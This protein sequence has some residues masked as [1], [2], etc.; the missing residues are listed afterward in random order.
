M[1]T[2]G[3]ISDTHG[4]LRPQALAALQGCDPIIHAGDVGSPDILPAL[5]AIAPVFPVRGNVDYGPWAD[6]LPPTQVIEIEGHRIYVLH[7]LDELKGD[8]AHGCEAVIYG[9]SHQPKIETRNGTL[10]FNPGSAGPRRFRL[11]ITLGRVTI[12]NGKL[13]AS[14]IDLEAVA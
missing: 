4:L 5:Q 2:I 11:P 13:R 12:E 14:L 9:H 10:F 3:V 7:I 1:R 8:A 6:T